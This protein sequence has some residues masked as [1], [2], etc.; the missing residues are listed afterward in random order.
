MHTIGR[1]ARYCI[2]L[3]ALLVH[4]TLLEHVRVWGAAPDVM[5]ACVIFF[6]LFLGPAAGLESGI[7]AG[8]MKDVFA[9]DYFGINMFIF[10]LIGLVAGSLSGKL[11]RESKR[12]RALA[13]FFLTAASMALHFILSSVFSQAQPLRFPEY[14]M[15]SVV[16]ASAYTAVVSVFIFLKLADR[17]GLKDSEEYL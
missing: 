13:V 10:A 8:L 16:P 3:I 11:S 6:G 12:L 4:C 2:L 7:A 14:F 1:P 9:L 5:L 17:Y 15:S